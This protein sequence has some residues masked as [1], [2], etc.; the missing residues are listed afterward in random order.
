[1]LSKSVCSFI[2]SAKV[3]NITFDNGKINEQNVAQPLKN[4]VLQKIPTIRAQCVSSRRGKRVKITKGFIPS[5]L[6]LSLL[7]T[8]SDLARETHTGGRVGSSAGVTG[9]HRQR[10]IR[11]WSN[12]AIF[13][14]LE[15]C[16]HFALQGTV[17]FATAE[18]YMKGKQLWF[19]LHSIHKHV[20]NCPQDKA[21]SAPSGAPAVSAVWAS[22]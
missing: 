2:N 1:M 22:T 20:R 8:K 6:K 10:Y 11:V 12:A 18:N 14:K 19:K 17:N 13:I 3:W 7:K 15:S 5:Q 9:W 4:S 16:T 21:W